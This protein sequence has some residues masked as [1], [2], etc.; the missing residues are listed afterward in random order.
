MRQRQ[1]K[2]RD[3]HAEVVTF[4]RLPRPQGSSPAET[5]DTCRRQNCLIAAAIQ[6]QCPQREAALTPGRFWSEAGRPR[7]RGRVPAGNRSASVVGS[8]MATG[9][10]FGLTGH[11]PVVD[12]G[13]DGV[14]FNPDLRIEGAP[15]PRILDH[16]SALADTTRSRILLLLDRHELTVSELCSIMQLPQSTVSRH[17][18]ALADSGWISARA[19]GTSNLY[20]MTRDDLD[21]SAKPLVGARSRAGGF[22]ARG[23]AGSAPRADGPRRTPHEIAGIFLVVRGTVGSL[24]RRAVRRALPPLRAVGVCR[25]GMDGRRSGMRH[26][27]DDRRARTVRRVVSWPWTHPPPCSRLPRS[28]SMASRTSSCGAASSRP[29]RSMMAGSMRQQWRSCSTTWRSPSAPSPRCLE[30][31]KPGGRALDCRHAA[32]RSRELSPADGARMARVFR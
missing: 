8:E 13:A 11:A 5:R 19:E 16:L 10:I 26:G 32:A 1:K 30:C 2:A 14:T 9:D 7:N 18:K 27:T 6:G 12:T 24:A 31:S 23:R 28:A 20:A 25:R 17:L 15:D 22:D 4:Q 3:A 29:F 21:A